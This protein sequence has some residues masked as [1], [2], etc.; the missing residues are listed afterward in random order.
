MSDRVLDELK[1]FIK[2]STRISNNPI[3]GDRGNFLYIQQLQCWIEQKEEEIRTRM[4]ASHNC[5]T[6]QFQHIEITEIPCILCNSRVL[7]KDKWEKKEE[8]KDGN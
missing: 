3:L 5:Y 6:C 8:K 4:A 2:R 1:D 7:L